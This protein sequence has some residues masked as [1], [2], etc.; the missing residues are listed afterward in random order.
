MQPDSL[1]ARLLAALDT[2]IELAIP[3]VDHEG[4]TMIVPGHGYLADEFEVAEYR[5][6]V[7][8]VR[9][10]VQDGIKQGMTLDQIK[11]GR[12]TQAYPNYAARTGLSSADGFVEAIYKSLTGKK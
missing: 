7:T 11:K 1:E 10:I 3:D 12:P 4:G 8:I 9:D 5:D 6:M 2:I